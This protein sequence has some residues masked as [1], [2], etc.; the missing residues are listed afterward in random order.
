M[1]EQN[2]NMAA[3]IQDNLGIKVIPKYFDKGSMRGTWRL[4]WKGEK[5]SMEWAEKF[6]A[7]GFTDCWNKSL[8]EFS[9]NGGMFQLFVRHEANFGQRAGEIDYEEGDRS[10]LPPA[11]NK[12]DDIIEMLK[13]AG[14][15]SYRVALKAKYAGTSYEELSYLVLADNQGAAILKTRQKVFDTPG[16]EH[17]RNHPLQWEVSEIKLE[18][19]V[20]ALLSHVS[21]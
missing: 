11:N 2:R 21:K 4:Y 10:K 3:F 17:L 9:G 1:L 8:G 19:D 12:P 18:D 15:T 7:L 14:T 13:P 20:I 6:N 5:W 16:L